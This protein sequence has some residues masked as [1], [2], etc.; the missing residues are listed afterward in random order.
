MLAALVMQ[1]DAPREY[2]D[3]QGRFRFA[4]P[5]SF[6]TASRGTNDGFGD[7]VA[8]VLESDFRPFSREMT[9]SA[10]A[11]WTA[12]RFARA[13]IVPGIAIPVTISAHDRSASLVFHV[14]FEHQLSRSD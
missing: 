13:G 1:A 10:G 11:R 8:A 5:S 14:M 6:G 3:P 4:Y 12:D 2:V 9:I 7:R